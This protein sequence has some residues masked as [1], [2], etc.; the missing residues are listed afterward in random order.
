MCKRL[1]LFIIYKN[2]AL[3]NNIKCLFLNQKLGGKMTVTST[4]AGS[5]SS[6]SADNSDV[7]PVSGDGGS[8]EDQDHML[9]VRLLLLY[10]PF[11]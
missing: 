3:S 2:I 4:S 6:T 5:E 11:F 7:V 10:L 9:T 1:T 8:E